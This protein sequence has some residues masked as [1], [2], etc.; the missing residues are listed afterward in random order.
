MIYS[1]AMFFSL[2]LVRDYFPVLGKFIVYN[3]RF[4]RKPLRRY[5]MKNLKVYVKAIWGVLWRCTAVGAFS[6]L[7]V[8][9]A[10]EVMHPDEWL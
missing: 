1:R 9:H 10:R 3:E 8:T 5:C 7:A 2:E 6:V 4:A